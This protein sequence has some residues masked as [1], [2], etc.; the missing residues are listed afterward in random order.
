MAEL[1]EEPAELAE[2]LASALA[3]QLASALAAQPAEQ[4]G[5]AVASPEEAEGAAWARGRA[6]A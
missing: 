2:Q 5:Q 1:A 6:E 4:V 3:E